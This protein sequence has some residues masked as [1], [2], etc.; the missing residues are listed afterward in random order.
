MDIIR[1]PCNSK[2]EMYAAMAQHIRDIFEETDD[3]CAALANTSAM[4]SLYLEDVN[5]AGFYLMKNGG[6]VLGPFQGKPAVVHIAVGD[7]VCGTAVKEGK[8]QRV[9]DV[10]SCCNHIACD[11]AT[12]SEIV[13]PIM[14]DGCIWGVIDIDSPI[15]ARFDMEDEAGMKMLAD[16]LG[17][18]LVSYAKSNCVDCD[19]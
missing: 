6:L 7:G 2:Q 12:A 4:L 15:P 14:V 19:K 5:W 3:L 13:S 10:R 17:N 9:D 11:L 8:Q 16:A 1:K 18:Q